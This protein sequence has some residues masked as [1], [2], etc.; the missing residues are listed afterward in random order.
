MICPYRYKNDT[1]ETIKLKNIL[2]EAKHQ[3]MIQNNVIIITD[4]KKYVDYVK[5]KYGSN[6]L[7]M[8]KHQSKNHQT[9][10]V[11]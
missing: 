2:A 10:L 11:S 7:K 5:N 3:C 6:F 1:D 4:Y 9:K 8:H